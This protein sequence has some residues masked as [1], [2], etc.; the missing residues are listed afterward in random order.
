MPGIV[1]SRSLESQVAEL[2]DRLLPH[3][4]DL[5]DLID[6]D[7]G[8]WNSLRTSLLARW[9]PD[10]TLTHGERELLT[11]QEAAYLIGVSVGRRLAGAR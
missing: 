1:L 4:P 5:V 10:G 11:T 3:C 7:P 2:A 6:A 8:A 9:D